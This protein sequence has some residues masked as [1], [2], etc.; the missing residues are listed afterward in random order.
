MGSLRTIRGESVTEKR[1]GLIPVLPPTPSLDSSICYGFYP[2]FQE[3][4]YIYA[5][6][7]L[8]PE[9]ESCV[10]TTKYKYNR[11]NRCLD[12]QQ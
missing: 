9:E 1:M 10:R 8:C 11:L 7:V 12:L 6:C 5:E 2:S 3:K 4:S